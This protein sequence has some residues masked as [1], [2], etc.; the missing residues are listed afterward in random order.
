VQVTD[1][2][3]LWVTPPDKPSETLFNLLKTEVHF[4]NI[5][6]YNLYLTESTPRL[7]YEDRPMLFKEITAVRPG[8]HTKEQEAEIT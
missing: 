6:K 4:N 3:V 5:E 7:H 1:L 8:N 2:F